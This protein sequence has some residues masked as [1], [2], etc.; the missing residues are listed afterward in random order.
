MSNWIN[1]EDKKPED[2]QSILAKFKHGIIDCVYDEESSLGMT[3]VWQNIQFYIY[4]WMPLEK[5][6]QLLKGEL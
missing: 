3:Y 1:F 4:E 2:G 6:E 5:A